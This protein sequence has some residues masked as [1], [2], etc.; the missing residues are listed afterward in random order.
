MTAH[1]TFFH[2]GLILEMVYKLVTHIKVCQILPDFG[3]K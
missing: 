3:S 2:N 1:H